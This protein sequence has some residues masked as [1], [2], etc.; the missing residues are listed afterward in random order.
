MT[1]IGA[2]YEFGSLFSYRIPDFSSQYAL[3]SPLPGPS[4]IKL[5]LV[6]TAIETKDVI[7]GEKVFGTIKNA[8]IKL[9]PP[10]RIALSNVLV[11]RLKAKKERKE[12]GFESTF[13]IRGY[14]H[15]AE[16]LKIYIETA[17]ESGKI[18]E[19]IE[20]LLRRIRR[21]GTSDS[22]VYCESVKK[23]IPPANAI[24][25]VEALK[26]AEKNVLVIPVKDLNPDPA[27]KFEHINI[28]SKSKQP[29]A[30][31]FVSK[32]YT[33]PILDQKQGKNWIVYEIG[34]RRN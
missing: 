25:A 33:I 1:W 13:G 32:F 19:E 23:E 22:V 9:L 6:A 28:Y 16:P 31:V 4:T 11:K 21:L 7:Y 17:I 2:I 18:G 8:K 15:F 20:N 3:S 12:K 30:K 14:V 10:K 26:K 27:I 5:A 29:K 24:E 34:P